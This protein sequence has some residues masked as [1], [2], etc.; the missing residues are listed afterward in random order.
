MLR[1]SHISVY[2]KSQNLRLF[3]R[4]LLLKYLN[5]SWTSLLLEMII[6]K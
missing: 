3:I 4:L 2:L 6:Y 5:V 1:L